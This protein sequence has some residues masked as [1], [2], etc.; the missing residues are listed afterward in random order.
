MSFIQINSPVVCILHHLVYHSSP[1]PP[2]THLHTHNIDKCVYVY[3]YI[4]TSFFLNHQKINWTPVNTFV[5]V[6]RT[7]SYATIYQNQ[8]MLTFIHYII[9]SVVHIQVLLL[10]Q[11]CIL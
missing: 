8:E 1:P 2:N 9:E 11:C 5:Y 7:F 10:S 4:C 3:R 6:L